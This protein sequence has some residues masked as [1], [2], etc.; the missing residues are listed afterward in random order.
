MVSNFVETTAE[1]M[2]VDASG[3]IYRKHGSGRSARLGLGLLQN[4]ATVE[5]FAMSFSADGGHFEH[6]L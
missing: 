1:E 3:S 6:Q 2:K 4:I 5:E